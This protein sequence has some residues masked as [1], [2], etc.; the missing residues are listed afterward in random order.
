[1]RCSSICAWEV[2]EV[3]RGWRKGAVSV[4]VWPQC[5]LSKARLNHTMRPSQNKKERE[6]SIRRFTALAETLMASAF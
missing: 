4:C 5:R 3:T 6:D 1:M 2:R